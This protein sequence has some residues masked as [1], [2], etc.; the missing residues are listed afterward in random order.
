MKVLATTD[1]STYSLEALERMGRIVPRDAEVLLLAV[2]P[3]PYVAALPAIGLGPINM[4][5]MEEQFRREAEQFVTEGSG[6]LERGGF[7][8]TRLVR[9]GD[10][11]M[12]IL[13]VAASEQVDLIV[14]GSH[15]RRALARFLLGS[16]ASQVVAHAPCSVL[17]IKHSRTP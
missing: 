13:E 9:E 1:G 15:G 17:V 12:T 16:V 3:N 6:I 8:V 4:A 10:V 14:V 11:A 5:P 7:Q 2:Y